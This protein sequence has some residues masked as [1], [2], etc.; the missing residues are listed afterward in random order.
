[1]TECIA[2]I[3]GINVGKAKRI[4]MADLRAMVAGL[5]H[6]NVRT[7]LNSGNI[8][9]QATRPNAGKL[10]AAIQA[11]IENECGVS[12]RVVVF[13]AAELAD[14]VQHNPL[15]EV[16]TDPSR[17]LVA[18]ASQPGVLA[19]AAPLVKEPFAPDRLVI[20]TRVAYLWCASGILD[21]KL[22]KAFS[23]ATG[24]ATTARNWT[25]VLK[26]HAMATG[27]DA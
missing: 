14:V 17:F 20:G 2:L 12:A 26:L 19:K 11:G 5:G 9:F 15:R 16:A 10:A 21:S 25:T 13:T 4:A 24:D 7:L 18:F 22:L 6:G 8:V 23:K 3:R 1:M 27:Q